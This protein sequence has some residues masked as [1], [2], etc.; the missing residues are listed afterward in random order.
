MKNDSESPSATPEDTMYQSSKAEPFA[1]DIEQ[2]A[3]D[4]AHL[5][6]DTV[7]NF[8]WQGITVVVKDRKTKEPKTI[9]ENVEGFVKAGTFSNL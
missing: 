6:N 8:G 2:K 9:L 1:L 7:R 3:V 5:M 4:D